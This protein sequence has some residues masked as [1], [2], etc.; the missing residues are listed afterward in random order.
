MPS[1][2]LIKDM[3]FRFRAFT[4]LVSL[5]GNHPLVEIVRKATSRPAKHNLSPIDILHALTGLK[6][7]DVAPIILPAVEDYTLG[8]QLFSLCLVKIRK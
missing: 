8:L 6:P 5:K 1:D 7:G 3:C 4:R 2:L